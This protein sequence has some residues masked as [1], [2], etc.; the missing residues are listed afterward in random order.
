MYNRC[1]KMNLWQNGKN[2]DNLGGGDFFE[3]HCIHIVS[4]FVV[5]FYIAVPSM[6]VLV[7][8]LCVK[9]D[10]DDDSSLVFV[11]CEVH[12]IFH[13]CKA[14]QCLFTGK[15]W[16]EVTADIFLEITKKTG[17]FH[18]CTCKS[19]YCDYIQRWKVNIQRWTYTLWAIF[20]QFH[21]C[22]KHA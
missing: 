17:N 3:S 13:T 15:V 14:P 18:T 1:V 6:Y 10:D 2:S 7:L 19:V 9:N 4:C 21:S 5:C 16:Q 20:F 22:Y 12:K 11:N 8:H